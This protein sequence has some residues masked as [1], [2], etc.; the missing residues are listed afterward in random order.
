[1]LKLNQRVKEEEAAEGEGMARD[2]HSACTCRCICARSSLPVP[3][4][5]CALLS[6]CGGRALCGVWCLVCGAGE[7]EDAAMAVDGDAG[8][9]KRDPSEVKADADADADAEPAKPARGRGRPSARE[10]AAREGGGGGGDGVI[11]LAAEGADGAR[12]L[13]EVGTARDEYR[14][15]ALII[16]AAEEWKTRAERVLTTEKAALEEMRS[17]VAEG[18]QL[19]ISVEELE[20]LESMSKEA[21]NWLSQA[22]SLGSSEA[23]LEDVQK[24]VKQYG[25][26]NL[27][28][29][30][31]DELRERAAAG[32]AWLEACRA[33][34]KNSAI[35]LGSLDLI[36]ST[37]GD[38]L[39]C[40]CRQP[41][42]LQ[43]LMIECED[44]EIWY[45]INCLGIPPAKAKAFEREEASFRCPQCCAKQ[46]TPFA[47]D[48][49]VKAPP[50]KRLP[51]ARKAAEL[52]AQADGL[53]VSIEEADLLRAALTRAREWQAA[54]LPKL[55]AACA[56]EATAKDGGAGVG[57][58]GEGGGNGGEAPPAAPVADAAEAPSALAG[59]AS[60]VP[61]SGAPPSGAPPSGAPASGAPP[62]GAPSR[63]AC[64]GYLSEGDLHT[65]YEEGEAFR[66]ESELH[67]LLRSWKWA[68]QLET[69]GGGSAGA[70]GGGGEARIPLEVLE[71]VIASAKTSGVAAALEE[72]CPQ[73]ARSRVS[74][75]SA[76]A[77]ASAA[78]SSAAG[79]ARAA[80][81]EGAADAPAVTAADGSIDGPWR[82]WIDAETSLVY[83]ELRRASE[84]VSEAKEWE[85]QAAEC[86]GGRSACDPTKLGALIARGEALSVVVPSIATLSEHSERVVG[87]GRHAQ[88]LVDTAAQARGGTLVGR[89]PS[90]AEV[91]KVQREGAKLCASGAVWEGLLA[92]L[93]KAASALESVHRGLVHYHGPEGF[94]QV[95]GGLD[96][97]GI[98]YEEM[99]A[100]RSHHNKLALDYS[101]AAPPAA[102]AA[103]PPGQAVSAAAAAAAANAAASA[104]AAS[105]SS[106]AMLMA[107]G[108]VAAPPR[109]MPNP[110]MPM[111]FGGAG[112]GPV[113]VPTGPPFAAGASAPFPAAAAAINPNYPHPPAPPVA[114]HPTAGLAADPAAAAAAANAAANA[115]GSVFTAA[116][117]L[118]CVEPP[119]PNLPPLHPPP[120]PAPVAARAPSPADAPAPRSLH[121]APHVGTSG[122]GG[123]GP[124]AGAGGDDKA[125]TTGLHG[126]T[127]KQIGGM[128]VRVYYN[129]EGVPVPYGGTVESL[130][131][132]RGLRVRLD[133]YSKREWVTDEDEWEWV[134]GPLGAPG[135]RPIEFV[136]G[137]GPF[138]EMLTR[139]NK[140]KELCANAAKGEHTPGPPPK[141][142]RGAPKA[143]GA[144]GQPA[145]RAKKEKPP[146]AVGPDGAPLDG[147]P[148]PAKAPRG[149]AARKRKAEEAAA[150]AAAV[151]AAAGLAQADPAGVTAFGAPA[152]L[153]PAATQ[154]GAPP[155]GAMAAGLHA[156]AAA[157]AMVPPQPPAI[158]QHLALQPLPAA[159]AIAPPP[160]P[161][162]GVVAA[163]QP[164]A[165]VPSQPLQAHPVGAAAPLPPAAS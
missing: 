143:A 62:S 67:V 102:S 142:K 56:G 76:S 74:A 165:P 44:C 164:A 42:D 149:G 2:R 24:C 147:A 124:A 99:N 145:K 57:G 85:T 109:T 33:L 123:G 117:D 89:R 72:A 22:D 41:D 25:K 128:R 73:P 71:Q 157:G 29:T 90:T 155:A 121:H 116:S 54:T 46:A 105:A 144:D 130:D 163:P 17:L 61:A 108:G 40:V 59:A 118:M 93:T 96:A 114:A 58:A 38:P 119:I 106:M 84:R 107:G 43:R 79:A 53:T 10:L 137:Y 91:L 115:L 39:Y 49:R 139:L 18:N 8:S 98:T 92:L 51:S 104:A 1:M 55:L 80:M 15:L 122:R 94:S 152:K 66:V 12:G 52:I 158:L 88:S 50:I 21:E 48:P 159:A 6:H 154:W 103:P 11:L 113:P 70:A 156:I 19:A 127:R 37:D 150:V 63:F 30:R 100:L 13:A 45:H 161:A 68:R 32:H 148:P 101:L 34:F 126:I 78:A 97:T 65:W 133:G 75:A 160:H 138:R 140:S 31:V 5:L 36:L 110:M 95:L 3:L 120:A 64:G 28:S 131:V 87:W 9:G 81:S 20:W 141:A 86:V 4:H 83:A 35:Q 146:A 129:E 151:A 23:T 77:S 136:I 111:P 162:V 134:E 26:I 135:P 27:L 112:M 82:A 153:V 16:A 14:E 7:G 132:K 47:W 60:G 125:P 69:R